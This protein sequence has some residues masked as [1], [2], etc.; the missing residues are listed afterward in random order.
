MTKAAFRN[1]LVV[2][3]AI[4]G[5]TNGLIHL[6]AAAGRCGI[7]ID[8]DELDRIG[9]EVPVLID[10]KPSGEHYMEHF[11]WAGGVPRL[12]AEL[13]DLLD[14]DAPTVTGAPLRSYAGGAE[15]VAG[16]DVIRSVAD[17]IYPRAAS[18]CCAAT[19]RRAARS[20]SSRRPARS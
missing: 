4:G 5:S 7:A 8:L 2:L 20:S 17:P 18:P 16:Q 15:R 9:R 3:Q 10:L 6:T 11:H 19:W 1:A 14:L 12:L 13:G